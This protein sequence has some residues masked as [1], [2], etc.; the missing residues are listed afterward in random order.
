VFSVCLDLSHQDFVQVAR[1]PL[2]VGVGLVAQFVLLPVATWAATLALPLPAPIE[3][4]M[5]LVACCPGGALSNV[6]THLSRGNL[7]LSL[8]ISAVSNVVAMVATPLNFAWMIS[9]NPETAQWAQQ[10]ALSPRDMIVSLVLLLGV[11]MGAAILFKHHLPALAGRLRKPLENFALVC[12]GLFVVGAVAGQFKAFVASLTFVLPLVVAHN[13][14]GLGL[15]YG[16]SRLVRLSTADTRAVTIESG[17]QNSG[18]ALG[19]IALQFGAD[20]QM[21]SVAG[22]WGIWH[23]VSGFTLARVWKAAD[24]RKAA[25]V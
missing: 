19:I 13:A 6:I 3:A 16:S 21:T 5:I 24:Q 9:N 1:N 14:L 12:L 25:H 22:L 15:G 10:I 2:G 20:L 7:A 4:G 11:P 17:M 23:I 18:L 8:S